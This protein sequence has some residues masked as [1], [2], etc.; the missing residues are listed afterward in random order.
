MG[1]AT[2]LL[3]VADAI[4]PRL[5]YWSVL[6]STGK[7]RT[8]RDLVP[9]FRAGQRGVR[10]LDWTLDL[11]AT[12]DSRRIR[13]IALC[14]PDGRRA[15]LDIVESGTVFQF[16]TAA[17]DGLL[18][19]GER[20]LEFQAIGRVT[21]KA[22]GTCECF[23]WDYRPAPGQPQLLAYKSTIMAFGSWRASLTPLGALGLDVQGFRL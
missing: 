11:V 7:T 17:L 13:E 18:S 4:D 10:R 9:T 6:L 8:E 1:V 16:K 23:V 15:T 20:R 22:S 3:A 19:A 21:D 14:C 2:S 5:A 12:G